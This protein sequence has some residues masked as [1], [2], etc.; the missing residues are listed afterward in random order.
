M[1]RFHCRERKWRVARR[2]FKEFRTAGIVKRVRNSVWYPQHNGGHI[3]FSLCR[4]VRTVRGSFLPV[5][6]I[7]RAENRALGQ[8]E[9]RGSRDV[10]LLRPLF[11]T[12]C[13]RVLLGSATLNVG[14]GTGTTRMVFIEMHAQPIERAGL[15]IGGTDRRY[16]KIIL[17]SRGHQADW[18]RTPPSL[19]KG[20]IRT[21]M[22]CSHFASYD[23][24]YAYG[25]ILQTV[26]SSIFV[27]VARVSMTTAFRRHG[28]RTHR[29]D[30]QQAVWNVQVQS[31]TTESTRYKCDSSRLFPRRNTGANVLLYPPI[32]VP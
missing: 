4:S 19:I 10:H 27:R 6:P 30:T 12:T 5:F 24:R 2:R 7:R 16:G 21:G 14:R 32:G 26:A 3:Q 23:G 18:S 11:S 22:E 31:S 17:R 9:L 1:E 8:F 28:M 13:K 25:K 15:V 20:S 29:C